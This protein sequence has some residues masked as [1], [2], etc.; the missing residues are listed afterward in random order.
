M[1]G[2]SV[3]Y[4]CVTDVSIEIDIEYTNQCEAEMLFANKG[5]LCF[6]LH[7]NAICEYGLEKKLVAQFPR[8]WQMV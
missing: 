7:F 3:L 6:L 2:T 5:T 4:M 1:Y 8:L